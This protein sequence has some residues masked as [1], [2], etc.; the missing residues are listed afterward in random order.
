M[1]GDVETVLHTATAAA[2]Q[3][4]VSARVSLPPD[5]GAYNNNSHR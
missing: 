2:A 3:D 4:S 5:I 1:V